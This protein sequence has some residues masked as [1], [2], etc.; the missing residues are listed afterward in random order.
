[1]TSV[2]E[3]YLGAT[4]A[5]NLKVEAEKR[6]PADI[7]IAV[8]WSMSRVGAALLRLTSEWDGAAKP[9][10]LSVEDVAALAQQMRK[11]GDSGPN[12]GIAQ[13]EADKWFED[14]M[15]LLRIQLKSLRSVLEQVE[16]YMHRNGLDH[17]GER[18]G[19]IVGWW[20][21]QHC[22]ACTGLRN[23]KILGAPVLGE[24]RCK[25]CHGSGMAHIPYGSAGRQVGNWL[26]DCLSRGRQATRE[27]LRNYG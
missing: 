27:R 6:G 10:P 9:R 24:R 8:G 22:H 2:D 17:P 19:P 26:D 25:I 15:K 3:Q 11:K 4:N 18:A 21:N 1:M 14:E 16:G 20:L 7:L 5:S 23:E 12:M 13:R